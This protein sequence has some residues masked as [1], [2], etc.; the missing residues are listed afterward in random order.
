LIQAVGC[1]CDTG[2]RGED[3]ERADRCADAGCVG[4]GDNVL[5]I[6]PSLVSMSVQMEP[7]TVTWPVRK[8][9]RGRTTL[10]KG[11]LKG[12]LGGKVTCSVM[13]SCISFHTHAHSRVRYHR[14]VML[15][16]AAARYTCTIT[17]IY[18]APR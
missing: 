10:M 15:S 5:A 9:K 2:A 11:G 4:G 7:P 18:Y 14:D 1:V 3:G 13:C 12:K 6:Q 17:S 16:S 8:A